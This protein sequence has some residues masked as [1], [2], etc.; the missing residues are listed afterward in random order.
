MT[1]LEDL[2]L[3]QTRYPTVGEVRD[4]SPCLTNGAEPFAD[5]SCTVEIQPNY[6]FWDCRIRTHQD[7]ENRRFL[8]GLPEELAPPVGVI[9]DATHGNDATIIQ[10]HTSGWVFLA[11]ASRRL[12]HGVISF[13]ARTRR[14]TA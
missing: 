8:A 14:R 10:W 4:V 1:A 13:E 6:V 7:H 5:E 12:T 3:V 2:P 11:D 9:R